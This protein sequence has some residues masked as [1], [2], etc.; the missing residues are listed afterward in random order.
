MIVLGAQEA[1]VA[2]FDHALEMFETKIRGCAFVSGSVPDLRGGVTQAVTITV[3][4]TLKLAAVEWNAGKEWDCGLDAMRNLV[5]LLRSRPN[6]RKAEWC[7][8]TGR[9][10]GIACYC[11][12]CMQTERT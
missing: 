1:D 4:E 2:Y 6:W 9:C 11:I 10:V 3:A 5:Q 8:G 7:C 12:W